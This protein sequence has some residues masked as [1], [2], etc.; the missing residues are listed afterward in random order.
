MWKL[1]ENENA[2]TDVTKG[3]PYIIE[4]EIDFLYIDPPYLGNNT[5]IQKT[6]AMSLPF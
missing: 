6:F 2:L 1:Y 5:N 3:L 4:I